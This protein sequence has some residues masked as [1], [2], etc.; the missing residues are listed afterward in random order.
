MIERSVPIPPDERG[1]ASLAHLSGLAGYV[2]PLGGIVVPILLWVT[3]RHATVISGLVKQAIRLN[4]AVYVCLFVCVLGLDL[5]LGRLGS[6]GAPEMHGAPAFLLIAGVLIAA[7]LAAAVAGVVL[8]VVGAIKAN[9]GDYYRYPLI[10]S[11]P[12]F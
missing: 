9:R 4:V 8:P 5:V 11:S 6:L 1:R 3:H 10:G 2:I 7:I 12:R